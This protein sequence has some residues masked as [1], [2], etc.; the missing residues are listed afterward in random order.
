MEGENGRVK[1]KLRQA[2]SIRDDLDF[3]S[4]DDYVT[5]V[6]R[7]VDLSNQRQR[8]QD[9]LREERASLRPL[10]E[11]P[12]PEYIEMQRRVSPRSVINVYSC[13]YSVPCQAIGQKVTVRLYAERLEVY[14]ENQLRL[15][16]WDRVH[17]NDQSI[18]DYHHFFPDLMKNWGS[19]TRLSAADK[20]QMFPRESFRT[21]YKSLREWDSNGESAHGLDPDYQYVRI[22]HLASKSDNEE[23]VD[24]ALQT[25]LKARQPFDFKDVKAL[26]SPTPE[27]DSTT[28]SFDPLAHTDT[29]TGQILLF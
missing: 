21:T 22:L 27:E 12:A 17:G 20:E 24:R 14:G 15:A 2:L 1:E 7:V 10:P 16:T 4:E 29:P 5:F 19:F 23:A 25:L 9:K 26:V 11:M 13:E 28:E 3:V 18:I 6:R 8:I